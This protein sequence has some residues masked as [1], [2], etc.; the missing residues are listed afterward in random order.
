MH[1]I[2]YLRV[3]APK[4]KKIAVAV[5][6]EPKVIFATER[7][8][9]VSQ[10]V[11]TESVRATSH[12]TPPLGLARNFNRHR[13]HC[14]HTA[15][16]QRQARHDRLHLRVDFHSRRPRRHPLLGLH[17]RSQSAQLAEERGQCHG[18]VLR[19][20]RPDNIVLHPRL[21]NLR[22]CWDEVGGALNGMLRVIL[23]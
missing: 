13:L 16:L 21:R 22:E 17:V 5:R 6:I 14:N 23:V 18:R 1:D 10:D 3:D 8:F 2:E 11:P 20:V 7:T 15:E 9:M 4:G 19:Q 12:H